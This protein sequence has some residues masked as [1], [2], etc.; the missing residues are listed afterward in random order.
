MSEDTKGSSFSVL[1]TNRLPNFNLGIKTYH[2]EIDEDFFAMYSMD[3]RQLQPSRTSG[4]LRISP[5][6]MDEFVVRP[7][8]NVTIA[9]PYPFSQKACAVRLKTL[10]FALRIIQ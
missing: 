8:E 7:Q 6:D 3:R 4:H 2:P 1:V 5:V 10:E 9:W